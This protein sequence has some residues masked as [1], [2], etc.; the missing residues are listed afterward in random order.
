MK[1]LTFVAMY[2]IIATSSVTSQLPW[3]KKNNLRVIQ[4]NLPAYEAATINPDSLVQ[5]LKTYGANTLILNAGGI[6]AFY[7]TQLPFQ[8]I[9]PYMKPNQLGDIIKR[10]HQNN[11][12]VIARF[13]FS[14]IDKSIFEQHPDWAFIDKN[15]HRMVSTD[16][17][18][19]SINAP[20]VQDKAFEIIAEVIQLY[21][22]DGIFLNAPGY[23]T[24][25]SYEGIYHGIDQNEWDRKRFELLT[26][27]KKLPL[28]ENPKDTLFQKYQWFKAHTT[29]LW[30]LKLFGVVKSRNQNI[31]ICTY[32]GDHVDITRHESQTNVLPYYPY[33]SSDN[34]NS[35]VTSYPDLVVSN[36]HIQQ[37]SFQSR[38]NAVEPEETE[39][40]LWENIAN[41]SG[42]DMSM[43]G[44]MRDYEDER[45]YPVFKKIYHHHKQ[46]EK[47][48]GRY[49]SVAKVAVIEPGWWPRG[50]IMQEYRGIQLMLIEN[51]IPFD[52]I[53]SDQLVNLTTALSQYKAIVLPDIT[54]LPDES[55]RVLKS[56]NEQGTVLMA[57][58]STLRENPQALQD[59]FGAKVNTIIEDG[60]GQYLDV[61]QSE[62]FPGLKGQKMIML[63][64]NLGEYDLSDCHERLF[65]FLKK[66]RPGPPETIGGHDKTGFYGIG[67]KR[68]GL[69]TNA[70]IPFNIG[71]LYYLHGYEEHKNI[72]IDLLRHLAPAIQEDITTDAHPRVETI[73]NQFM[74][75]DS[76]TYSKPFKSDGMILHLMNTTG[77]GGNT[78]FSPS[79]QYNIKFKITTGFIPK[80][81]FNLDDRKKIRYSYSG[82]FVSFSLAELKEH[83]GVVILK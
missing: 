62:N 57:T 82:S 47:Y 22:V 15:G 10:C 37:I 26:G 56:I 9:N 16:K 30:Y 1:E 65:P 32:T 70:I 17:Y 20:Y 55:I 6:M 53:E 73:L 40:R 71:K 41:G 13:D 77:F 69:A 29:H 3:W 67:I 18:G 60:T 7:P 42:L 43:M 83:A 61:S 45:N 31:A 5:D 25:N 76:T 79:P 54:K 11:I 23:L 12:H 21:P 46:N 78:Y 50:N 35:S 2:L 49:H 51:H 64:F 39:I 4:Y 66:G 36:A 48:Y 33:N 8:Y 27:E 59:I 38:Y 52:R 74:Y 44:D 75:N 72:V 19:A 80:T 63:K 58:N 81:V 14:R 34:V 28:E 68:N 24:S